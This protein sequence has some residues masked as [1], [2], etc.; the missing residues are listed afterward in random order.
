MTGRAKSRVGPSIWS[1]SIGNAPGIANTS[2]FR[3]RSGSVVRKTMAST[4]A[5]GPAAAT[6]FAYALASMPTNR[7]RRRT[8]A[9]T[10]AAS[11]SDLSSPIRTTGRSC[12]M[13]SPSWPSS[14]PRSGSSRDWVSR[15]VPS[16]WAWRM[17][18]CQ[19]VFHRPASSVNDASVL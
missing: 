4:N 14:S 2:R 9:S 11:S 17:F 19:L 13:G 18:G 8:E 15:L 7:A 1:S 5:R 3:G 16:S 10:A 6:F 12:T